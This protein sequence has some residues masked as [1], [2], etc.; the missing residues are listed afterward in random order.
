MGR[1]GLL[2]AVGL[3]CAAAAG[4]F[5]YVAHLDAEA[6]RLVEEAEERLGASLVDAPE[7]DRLQASTAVSKLERARALGRS[8]GYV[9]GL[10]HY[11]RSIAYLQRGDLV[12]AE[13]EVEFARQ[14]LGGFSADLHLIMAEIARRKVDFEAARVHL[15]AALA[16]EPEHPRSLVM[17]A[18]LALDRREAAQARQ[19]FEILLERYPDV[20][21]L[22]NSHAL[23]LEMLGDVAGAEREL[24]EAIRLNDRAPGPFINLGRLL[25]ANGQHE[26]AVTVFGQAIARDDRE[27]DGWL[28]R[29]LSHTALG[30]HEEARA[31]LE[32]SA[33]LAPNDAEPLLALGDAL[34]NQG[35][36]EE[37]VTV[38]RR[39]IAREDADAASWLKLGNALVLASQPE[40][41]VGAFE[42]ALER[43]PM[44]AAA[45]NGLGAALMH[46]GRTDDAV[47]A[48]ERAAALDAHDPNPLLNLALLR[49]RAGDREGARA[50]FQQALD[51]DPGSEVARTH[52]ARLG[53]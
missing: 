45:H 2:A 40:D 38:Y 43:A 6:D 47:P 15:E 36:V 30:A 41:A 32:R 33:A 34:R 37:A 53:G 14:H 49:E 11:A 46:A 28:G 21:V 51:R 10:T 31:D 17:Q 26:D 23:A 42:E 9:V 29:G 50:A 7:L 44:L 20:A 1:K 12:F 25:A 19:R 18:E 16:M 48:L 13:R 27:P 8:E 24:R 52:V 5:A 39:A 35:N 22:R 4:V 3:S